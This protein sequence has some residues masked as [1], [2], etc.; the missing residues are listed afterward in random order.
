MA[1]NKAPGRD[2]IPVHVLQLALPHMM[3][4]LLQL[5]NASIDMQYCPKHFRQSVTLAIP[6]PGK[7]DHSEVKSYRPIALLN[8]L[9]HYRQSSLKEL[10]IQSRN[11]TFCRTDI[12]EARKEYRRT[13]CYTAW[14]VVFTRHGVRAVRLASFSWMCPECTTMYHI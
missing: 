3:S 10:H 2:G 13:I 14:L 12:V 4:H 1:P 7:K 9:R 11:T 6:K 5:Y 8:T